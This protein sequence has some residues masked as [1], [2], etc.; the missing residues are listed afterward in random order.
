MGAA[1]SLDCASLSNRAVRQIFVRRGDEF[2][3]AMEAILEDATLTPLGAR[4]C[5]RAREV[6]D[7]ISMILA[8]NFEHQGDDERSILKVSVPSYLIGRIHPLVTKIQEDFPEFRIEF[9]SKAFPIADTDHNLATGLSD[10]HYGFGTAD[11]KVE[12]GHRVFEEELTFF[13]RTGHPLLHVPAV[14]LSTLSQYD[15]FHLAADNPLRELVDRTW[16][17]A[18]LQPKSI[19]LAS[20]DWGLLMTTAAQSDAFICMFGSAGETVPGSFGLQKLNVS[21]ADLAPITIYRFLS[22][23]AAGNASVRRI[24]S[25]IDEK[26]RAQTKSR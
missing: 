22:Q 17:Q 14:S 21:A 2:I 16:A 11:M 3:P 26:L 5:D 19:V 25:R 4:V 13:V 6:L 10:V 7:S 1:S 8:E 24:V 20:D 9:V 18:G 15:A 23:R 12:G